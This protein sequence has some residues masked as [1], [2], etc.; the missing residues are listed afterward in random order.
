MTVETVKDVLEWTRELHQKI[1]DTYAETASEIGD[2]RAAMLLK[3]IAEHEKTL[4]DAIAKFEE[5]S[6]ATLMDTWFQEHLEKNPFMQN[7]QAFSNFHPV[8]TTEIM[9]ITVDA[10]Q[11]LIGMYKEFADL[12][13]TSHLKDLFGNLA[14]MEMG[15]MMR[16]VTSGERMSDM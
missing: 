8:D 13:K 14:D 4:A 2:E 11:A 10:H 7:F 9:K 15:E 1:S 6:S 16:I 5:H 12:A 3:Y